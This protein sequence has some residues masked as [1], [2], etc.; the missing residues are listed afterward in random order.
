MSRPITQVAAPSLGFL[1]RIGPVVFCN[2]DSQ[3]STFPF[4]RMSTSPPSRILKVSSLIS[5]IKSLHVSAPDSL[6]SVEE[7]ARAASEGHMVL[8]NSR[9]ARSRS[10]WGRTRSRE[11]CIVLCKEALQLGRSSRLCSRPRNS[12]VDGHGRKTKRWRQNPASI[13]LT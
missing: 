10:R 2:V 9:D 7:R 1:N 12:V 3:P 5:G 13:S 4:C 8:G 11:I 6:I